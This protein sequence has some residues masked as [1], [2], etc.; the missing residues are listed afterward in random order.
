MEVIQSIIE[1]KIRPALQEHK[2]DIELIEVSSDGFVKVRLI[3]ACSTCPGFQDTLSEFVETTIKAECPEI[4]GVEAL[5][6]VSEALIEEA[7]ELLHNGRRKKY[8]A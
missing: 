6:G 3:G 1:R 5:G 2:G 8:G 4:K 7:L